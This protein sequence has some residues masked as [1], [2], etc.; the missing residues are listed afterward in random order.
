MNELY[1]AYFWKNRLFDQLS[2]MTTDGQK[3]TVLSTGIENFHSG[4]DFQNAK[5]RIDEIEWVGSVELHVKASDWFLH[6]HDKDLAYENV[7]LHLIWE[8]DCQVNYSD[9]TRIPTLNLSEYL[10]HIS[11]SDFTEKLQSDSSILC[12]SFFDEV[13]IEIKYAMLEKCLQYRLDEKSNMIHHLLENSHFD[14]EETFFQSL[15]KSFGFHINAEPMLRLAQSISLKVILRYRDR[16]LAVESMLF[17]LAGFLAE[18][19]LDDY[20]TELRKEFIHLQKKHQFD[21]SFLHLS[22]WK[23]LRL[24]PYNFPTI[25]LAQFAEMIKSN[26]SLISLLLE[27]KELKTIKTLFDTPLNFYWDTHYHFGRESSKNYSTLGLFSFQSICINTLIPMLITYSKVKHQKEYHEKALRWLSELRLE[28]N[29]VVN[30]Y[31]KMKLPIRSAA[32][33]QACLHLNKH[34]CQ[35]KKCL[36][37]DIGKEIIHH[38]RL[39]QPPPH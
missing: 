9:G 33:S 22:D 38:P 7:V 32:D 23:F 19:M 10:A 35:Q 12:A 16:P 24:R 18:P 21:S 39:N 36:S 28:E 11:L 4:A 27:I 8:N 25:R 30:L 17:G 20:Q 5:I 13:S 34:Y 6:H 29:S 14:W 31:K 2:L 15:A 37:C 3:L 26:C 1:L